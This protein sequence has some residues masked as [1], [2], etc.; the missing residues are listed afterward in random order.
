[1]KLKWIK[2]LLWKKSYDQ[3]RQHIKMQ[4][5]YFAKKCPSSQSYG[6]S[7]SHVWM[8]ELDYKEGWTLKNWCF[9][10]NPSQGKSV[11]NIHWKDWCWGW[12]SNTL[13]TWCE[14]LTQWKIPWCWER[15][16]AGGEADNREWDGLDGINNLMNMSLSKLQEVVMDREAWCAAVHGVTKSRT[17]LSDWIEQKW[18]LTSVIIL[19]VSGI[20]SLN[21]RQ[22]LA[23]QI[24]KTVHKNWLDLIGKKANLKR[25][26][27]IRVHLHN[28]FEMTKF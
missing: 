11:L 22:K 28:I 15:L 5:H 14:E 3:P 9:W 21:K 13:A 19:K 4:R 10:T 20:N 25:L 6:F 8:W 17:Q 24:L 7:S 12:N 1:M 16:K 2:F 18:S 26:H 27:I 23:K